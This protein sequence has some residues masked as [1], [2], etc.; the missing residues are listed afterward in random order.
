MKNRNMMTIKTFRQFVAFGICSAMTFSCSNDDVEIG[1]VDVT[2]DFTYEVDA[3]DK[4]LI[5]FTNTSEGAEFYQWNFGD[6]ESAWDENTSHRY[7][8][9][10]DTYVVSLLAKTKNGSRFVK[11]EIYVEGNSIQR[12]TGG[13]MSDDEAW[14]IYGTGATQTT[15][16]FA[17]GKVKFSNGPGTV[18]TN[19]LLWQQVEINHEKIYK[20]S[21]EVAGGGASQSWLEI[22][23][24][25]NVPAAGSDYGTGKYIEINTWSGCGVADFSG[26]IS[27]IGCGGPGKGKN[28][29]ITFTESGTYYMVIKAGSWQGNL[30]TNGMTIDN[31]SLKEFQ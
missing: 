23:F 4:Q 26:D 29:K 17:D 27:V 14:T 19:V 10:E 3:T 16:A 12:V 11:K 22:Y 20:F 9:G 24:S 1:E 31:V 13:D 18:E 2:A 15:T 28:G 5:R 25:K 21:A 7:A 30:G 6:A 8:V